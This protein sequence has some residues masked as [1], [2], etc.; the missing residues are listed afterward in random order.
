M[1]PCAGHH[2]VKAVLHEMP[3]GDLTAVVPGQTLS[4]AAMLL[5]AEKLCLTSLIDRLMGL[6]VV[7]RYALKKMIVELIHHALCHLPDPTCLLALSASRTTVDQATSILQLDMKTFLGDLVAPQNVPEVNLICN[8]VDCVDL[9]LFLMCPLALV[10]EAKVAMHATLRL[11]LQRL[12]SATAGYL[13]PIVRSLLV[14]VDK[15]AEEPRTNHLP[16]QVKPRSLLKAREF[17][18]IGLSNSKETHSK[19]LQ[20]Q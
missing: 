11:T 14:R 6:V 8:T 2:I 4:M 15:V 20:L 10:P 5:L 19:H 1:T 12:V 13:P 17:T 16:P 3:S 9:S 7:M 18:Q